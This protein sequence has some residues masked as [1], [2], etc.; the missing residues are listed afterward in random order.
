MSS[1]KLINFPWNH[2]K[3]YGNRHSNSWLIH[4][5]LLFP[6]TETWRWSLTY[7]IKSKETSEKAGKICLTLSHVRGYLGMWQNFKLANIFRLQCNTRYQTR[8]CTHYCIFSLVLRCFWDICN[9]L[10]HVTCYH[11]FL[12]NVLIKIL[13][14]SLTV[15]RC[16]ALLVAQNHSTLR[17]SV[18]KRVW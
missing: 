16:N 4:L 12:L 18:R 14:I 1:S 5:N 2:Q 17:G 15:L 8:Y 6:R 13:W 7:L 3:I 9:A 11:Q 10:L